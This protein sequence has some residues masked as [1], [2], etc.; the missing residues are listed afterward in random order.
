MIFPKE[1]LADSLDKRSKKDVHSV[2]PYKTH[3]TEQDKSPAEIIVSNY[4]TFFDKKSEQMKDLM[5]Q[6]RS[7]IAEK[8]FG[9]DV[10]DVYPN[11]LKIDQ[12]IKNTEVKYLGKYYDKRNIFFGNSKF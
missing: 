1:F 3:F 11:A 10:M 12:C 8:C 9:Q 5:F 6:A 4:Y 7:E 2:H